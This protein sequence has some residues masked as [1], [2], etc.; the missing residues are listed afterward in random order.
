MIFDWAETDLGDFW[1]HNPSDPTSQEALHWLIQ[2]S[3]GMAQG[4]SKVHGDD[5]S[6][7]QSPS[8]KTHIQN[9]G[10]HGD[11]KPANILCF[12]QGDGDLSRL[13]LVIADFTLMRFHSPNSLG[14][15]KADGLG[16]SLS[17]RPPEKD[18]GDKFPIDQ[19]YDVWTLGCVYLE[20]LTWHLLGHEAVHGHCFQNSLG[21]DVQSF[22]EARIN[23]KIEKRSCSEDK[24]FEVTTGWLGFSNRGRVKDSVKK[25]IQ[26]LRQHQHCSQAIHDFLNLIETHMLVPNPKH[27]WKIPEICQELGR[28]STRCGSDE[29]YCLKGL[30]H[31]LPRFKKE[32]PPLY[33]ATQVLVSP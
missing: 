11:I 9:R 12:S 13:R 28:I 17:Y 14:V 19:P 1:E 5:D 24:F 18:M 4:L 7:Q 27:R 31:S 33:T 15:T 6:S 10:R 16:C 2:Q 8:H 3:H 21:Q 29:T 20:F 30:P 25:W 23:D 32:F 22:Q 26:F